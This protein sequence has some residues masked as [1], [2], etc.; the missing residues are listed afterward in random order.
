MKAELAQSIV[1]ERHVHGGLVVPM[2]VRV[3][4]NK[5]PSRVFLLSATEQ[6]GRNLA[7]LAFQHA[8]APLGELPA[9]IE[10]CLG[11]LERAHLVTGVPG[12]LARGYLSEAAAEGCDFPGE[13]QAP[14][15]IHRENGYVWTSRPYV[16]TYAAVFLGCAVCW[17]LVATEAQKSR[18][19]ALVRAVLD[20]LLEH[21]MAPTDGDGASRPEDSMKP[22]TIPL[23]RRVL[24]LQALQLLRIGH[25]ITG[26]ARYL[27]VYR[28][29]AL[30][31]D[32]AKKGVQLNIYGDWW[33]RCDLSAFEAYYHL[34]QYEDDPDLIAIYRRNLHLNWVKIQDQERVYFGIIGRALGEETPSSDEIADVLLRMDVVKEF[35]FGGA[36]DGSGPQAS[37]PVPIQERPP[38]LFEWAYTPFRMWQAKA[39]FAPV[40]YLI[41]YW[42]ARYHGLLPD[43]SPISTTG[44]ATA[45]EGL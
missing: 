28:E 17:D 32:Y 22:G 24:G 16:N 12:V 29:L 9:R 23:E 4:A 44:R 38:V 41:A 18:I 37:V 1:R 30:T 45:G 14:P 11:A 13:E 15:L 42:M 27:E 6:T 25:H 35:P 36:W 5:E 8:S 7:A 34:L 26:E 21:E 10:E 3:F 39:Y 19:A 2:F 40:D 20:R 43:S 31:H 33:P